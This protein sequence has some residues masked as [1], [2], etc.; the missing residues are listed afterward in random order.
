MN[1]FEPIVARES[2]HPHFVSA[3]MPA[4]EPE[5]A[6]FA[7]WAEGFVDRDGK[8]VTE[9]QTTFNTTFW[10]IYLYACLKALGYAVDWSRSAPDFAV[11]GRGLEFVIEAVTANAA[12]G[13]PSEWDRTFSP[14]EIRNLWPIRKLNVE[15]MIRLSNAIVSKADKYEKRYGELDHVKGKPFVVAVAPFEQPHFNIQYD[16]PI[17]ALLYDRYL[18]EDAFRENPAAHPNGVPEVSLGSITKDNGAKI[19]LGIFNDESFSTISAVVFSTTATWGKLSAM[20][21]DASAQEV[22]VQSNWATPPDGAPRRRVCSALEHDETVLDGLQV[23]HNPHA[24]FPL[25]PEAFRAP[26]VVQ[27]FLNRESST[28]VWENWNNTLWSRNAF[29]LSQPKR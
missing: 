28:W 19:R 24:R 4:R 1:F 16:R 5:R 23:F 25:S 11:E 10:E 22:T 8:V 29:R 27:H 14:K 6:L 3:C 17:R 26:R 12:Q 7:R 9:F 2:L 21:K 18:D 20:S 15:A 13:K